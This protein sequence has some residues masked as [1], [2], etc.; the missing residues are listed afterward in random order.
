MTLRRIW[1]NVVGLVRAGTTIVKDSR[2][3]RFGTGQT[4]ASCG[5]RETVI[6]APEITLRLS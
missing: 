5:A 3:A 6:V 2:Y 4:Y 1:E